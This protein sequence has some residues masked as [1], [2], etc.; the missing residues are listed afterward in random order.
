[1]GHALRREGAPVPFQKAWLGGTT[2]ADAVRSVAA[3]EIAAK[4]M[5]LPIPTWDISEAELFKS[6]TIKWHVV[7]VETAL[8]GVIAFPVAEPIRAVF[9]NTRSPPDRQFIEIVEW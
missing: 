8:L 4:S 7:P 6:G 9:F 5:F 2:G 3:S 1:L